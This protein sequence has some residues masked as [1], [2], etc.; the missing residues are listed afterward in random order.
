MRASALP[1]SEAAWIT[2]NVR[3]NAAELSVEIR[4]LCRQTRHRGSY[5][6][7]FLRP[8]QARTFQQLDSAAVQADVHTI[9]VVLDFVKPFGASA[10]RTDQLAE[11]R[12]DPLRETG[13]MVSRP[14]TH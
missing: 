7:I 9:P 4:L 2:L 14:A 11:L 12:L 8:V 1:Q 10:R 6:R 3:A 5:G 13:R